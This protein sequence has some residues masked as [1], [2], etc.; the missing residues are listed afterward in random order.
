MKKVL[1]NLA[2]TMIAG[3][4]LLGIAGCAATQESSIPTETEKTTRIEETTQIETT[5]KIPETSSTIETG[6][7]TETAKLEK[8]TVEKIE[9][10]REDFIMGADISSYLSIV[11]SGAVFRDWEGNIIDNETFFNL[12]KE[13][14]LNCARIRVWNN[15]YDK[16]GNGYGGGNCDLE[17]AKTLGTWATAAGLGVCI[18]FHYSDFWADPSKQQA[19]KEWKGYN[20]EQKAEALKEYTLESLKTLLDSGVNVA[21]VQIGNET[22]SAFCGVT[23]WVDRCTLFSA[24]S[25][26]VRQIAAEYEREIQVG[27]HFTN[28]EKGTYE[29]FASKLEENGVD[30]DVFAS[31]YYPFW[32][33]TL[34]NLTK[35]LTKVAEGYGK[36]VLVA[37]TS[38]AYTL[39]DGDGH[40]NTVGSG[41]FGLAYD[42]SVQGQADEIQSVIQAVADVGDAGIGIMYWEPAWIPVQTYD[43]KAADAE[44]VLTSNKEA[45][46][47]YGSGWATS[48]AGE[49]DPND[50]GKWYGGSAVD[51]QALFDFDGNP[52]ESLKTFGYVYTGAVDG[53]VLSGQ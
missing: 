29:F 9:N 52:L 4:I 31:S 42:V 8:I 2:G 53:E 44:K 36:Q 27:I 49:Y 47:K 3:C 38:W 21:M 6:T 46:E 16:N 23:D 13:A 39:E 33:G 1:R 10:L 12:L 50:A 35:Q 48:Y 18:D 41:T 40:G 22:T 30:Y 43:W 7:L 28:P 5:S 51:N 11:E 15:P 25:E 32:H 17:T 34:E 37:E 45:W 14:G 19:P 26:A 24:G 20:V